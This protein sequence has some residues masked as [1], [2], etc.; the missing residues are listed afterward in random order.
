MIIILGK[1]ITRD[2]SSLYNIEKI[3]EDGVISVNKREICI[4]KVN[5]VNIIAWDK[6]MKERIISSYIAT[7]K[8]MPD[9]FQ[10]V[11]SQQK[12]TLRNDIEQYKKR[13]LEVENYGLKMA[14][15]KYIEYLQKIENENGIY[16][17]KHY[18]IVE[19]T[20]EKGKENI[21][22]AFVNMNEFG[23]D[24]R[25]ITRKSEVEN[26]IRRAIEG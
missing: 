14:L 8:G 5:P 11:V 6:E 22:N 4:Y 16:E 15:K 20:G 23:L 3:T 19:E 13:L 21:H 2:V 1:F 24:I 10:I 18:L 25:K 26:V 12:S 17:I 7:L 9:T